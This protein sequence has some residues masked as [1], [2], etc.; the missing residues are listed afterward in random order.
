MIA[1]R[2]LLV[3]L[4]LAGVSLGPDLAVANASQG[5]PTEQVTVLATP[6]HH[7]AV[8]PEVVGAPRKPAASRRIHSSHAKPRRRVHHSRTSFVHAVANA[9]NDPGVTIANFAFSPGTTTVHVG[10]T[11]TWT[12]ED[13]APHTATAKDGSFDTGILTKG[14]SASHT[15]TQ[16][17]T[18]TYYCSVHPYMHGTVVVLAAAASAQSSTSPTSTTPPTSASPTAASSSQPAAASSGASQA[19]SAPTLP[20]TGMSVLVAAALGLL[21]LGG[22]LR[23][24]RSY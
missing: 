2:H 20:N 4:A 1:R 21:L 9:A 7:H 18:F 19:S 22:G 5:L 17:G 11:V 12:N 8:R 3:A 10:D 14:R 24:R 6:K 16:P 13:S 23:L 15:F